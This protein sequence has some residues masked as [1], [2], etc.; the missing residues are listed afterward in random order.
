MS[1]NL[2]RKSVQGLVAA[3]WKI[4]KMPFISFRSW[5][6]RFLFDP[7]FEIHGL[8]ANSVLN[9]VYCFLTAVYLILGLA[10]CYTI[11]FP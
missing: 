1:S 2:K 5:W 9:L 3:F 7:E 6:S 8:S 10:L 11:L 4:V